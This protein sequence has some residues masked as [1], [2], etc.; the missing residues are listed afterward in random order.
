MEA[1][2][3]DGETAIGPGL[4]ISGAN[5]EEKIVCIKLI[6]R[7]TDRWVVMKHFYW[8]LLYIGSGNE[9]RAEW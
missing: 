9:Q 6:S 8:D 5:G 3:R 1:A 7:K 4:G 2:N